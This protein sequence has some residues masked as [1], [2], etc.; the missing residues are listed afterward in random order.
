MLLLLWEGACRLFC[1][2]I[3]AVAWSLWAFIVAALLFFGA[4]YLFAAFS[5]ELFVPRIEGEPAILV[6]GKRVCGVA[7]M[8]G[9][10]LGF[11]RGLRSY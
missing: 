7:I 2:V 10:L 8:I 6:W 4:S 11:L 1:G 3:W 5:P 9:G